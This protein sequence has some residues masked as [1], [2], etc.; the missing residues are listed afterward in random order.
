MIHMLKPRKKRFC[1]LIFVPDQD[2]DPKSVSF[3]YGKGKL[4]LALLLLLAVHVIT[5]TIGYFRVI[6]LGSKNHFLEQENAD[7]KARNKRIDQIVTEFSQI[8]RTDEK[9]R[10]AFGATLGIGEK[11]NGKDLTP[12]SANAA[13]SAE[14]STDEGDSKGISRNDLFF[15]NRKEGGYYNPENLPT[16]LPVD[17]VL[18]TRYDD[19]KS[20]PGRS[21]RGI[22]I[23]AQKGTAIRASGSGVVLL[24]DWTPDFG[25]IVIISHGSEFYS[26]YGHL[27]QAFMVQGMRVKK[28]QTIGLVGSSGISSAPH[29]HF[30]IWRDG[31]SINPEKFLYA[32]QK[33]K[34]GTND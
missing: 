14:K 13:A 30:E 18:T 9:I 29:L 15:V 25:N 27:L 23:A 19:V 4:I 33:L 24:S 5:G 17:G 31:D 12:K 32:I 34:T 1:S 7:L 11:P 28:G 10:K 8:R 6:H 21:H 26:Y 2:Q 20:L 16:L 22:D 3:S